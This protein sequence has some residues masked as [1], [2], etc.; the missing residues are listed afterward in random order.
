MASLEL[1]VCQAH[2]QKVHKAP[3]ETKAYRALTGST[4]RR[5][6]L[7]T[8]ASTG[9]TARREIREPPVCAEIREMWEQSDLLVCLVSCEKV[10]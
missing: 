9:W 1:Q 7:G 2:L 8:P 10:T 6:T 5:V 3:K 4:V